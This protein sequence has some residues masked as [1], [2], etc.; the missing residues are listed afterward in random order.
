[1]KRRGW[2]VIL[3]S[4]GIRSDTPALIHPTN[5]AMRRQSASRRVTYH[6][7]VVAG[8]QC[9]EQVVIDA[10]WLSYRHVFLDSL[11]RLET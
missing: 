3:I 4:S 6:L 11:A 1:M 5:E 7:R 10:P 2:R 8:E 9:A